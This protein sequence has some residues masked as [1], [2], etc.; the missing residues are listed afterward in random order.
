MLQGR[1]QYL[2]F[3]TLQILAKKEVSMKEKINSYLI[4]YAA[5]LIYSVSSVC[6]KFSSQ[7]NT[8]TKAIVFLGLEMACL[9]IYAIIWQQALK[10]FSLVTAMASKGIVVIM[11][12]IWSIWLFEESVSICNIVGAAVIIWGIWVVSSDG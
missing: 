4:L 12:M 11:N 7:Q 5:F 9:G 2:L 8:L 1:D 3:Q 10:R 6:A